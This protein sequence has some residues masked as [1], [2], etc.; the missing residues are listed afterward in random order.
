MVVKA[1]SIDKTATTTNNNATTNLAVIEAYAKLATTLTSINIT[2]STRM[3]LYSVTVLFNA[4]TAL[5]TDLPLKVFFPQLKYSKLVS[6]TD[7]AEIKAVIIVIIPTFTLEAF[8]VI[9]NTLP[10]AITVN[11]T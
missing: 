6:N 4:L 11:N 2:N 1:T 3:L 9:T 7:K 5:L 8:F 10:T